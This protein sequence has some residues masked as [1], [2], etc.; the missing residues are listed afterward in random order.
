[1]ISLESYCVIRI[2][3]AEKMLRSNDPRLKAAF[4]ELRQEMFREQSTA[5]LI[6]ASRVP[7]LVNIQAG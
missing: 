7:T 5:E 3:L 4:N 1:M 6:D 2:A